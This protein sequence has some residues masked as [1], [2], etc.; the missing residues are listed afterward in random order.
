MSEISEQV[1]D[2][3]ARRA[4]RRLGWQVIKARRKLPPHLGGYMLIDHRRVCIGGSWFELS[5]GDIISLCKAEAAA[6]Y[7]AG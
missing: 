6:L 1:L 5:A 3:R 4:A 7:N 2:V